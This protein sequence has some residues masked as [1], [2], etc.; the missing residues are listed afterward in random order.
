[1]F[2][3]IAAF[4]FRVMMEEVEPLENSVLVTATDYDHNPLSM[5]SL[6]L[7]ARPFVF[8]DGNDVRVRGKAQCVPYRRVQ[9]R[10][11]RYGLLS[12]ASTSRELCRLS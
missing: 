2:R 11:A 10:H 7:S 6:R 12:E 9:S 5:T 8:I 4:V 1:M 3:K